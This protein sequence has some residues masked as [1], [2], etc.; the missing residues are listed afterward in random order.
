MHEG[1][2]A[3]P[4]SLAFPPFLLYGHAACRLTTRCVRIYDISRRIAAFIATPSELAS[5]H[6][7]HGIEVQIGRRKDAVADFIRD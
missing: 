7:R 3:A 2:C 5:G 4:L 1:T 6:K